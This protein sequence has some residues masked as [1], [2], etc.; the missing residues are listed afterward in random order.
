MRPLK[1]IHGSLPV[2]LCIA[3]LLA[4][5]SACSQRYWNRKKVNVAPGDTTEAEKQFHNAW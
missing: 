5:S 2:I 3:I 4:F 1:H